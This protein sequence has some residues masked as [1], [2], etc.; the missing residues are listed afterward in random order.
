MKKKHTMI[1]LGV[2][3]LLTFSIYAVLYDQYQ[4][5]LDNINLD[6]FNTIDS[7]DSRLIGLD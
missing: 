4:P 6:I 5:K 7:P 3:L 1:L 2:L